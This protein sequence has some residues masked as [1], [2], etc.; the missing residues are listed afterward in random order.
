MFQSIQRTAP[1][2]A[3]ALAFV[4]VLMVGLTG[5]GSSTTTTTAAAVTE[6]TAAPTTD[7]TATAAT[8]GTTAAPKQ[9]NIAYNYATSAVNAMQEMALGATAAAESSPGV[10]FTQASPGPPDVPKQVSL[11]QAAENTSKDGIAIQSLQ[12][13]LFARPAADAKAK[14]IP[15]V[16][17]DAPIPN[18]DLVISNSNYDLG[19][20][21]ATEIIKSIPADAK[22]E[23]VMGI[24]V[25][26]LS[27]LEQRI[28]GMEDVLK[29]ERPGLTFAGPYDT[30]MT[31]TEA[32]AAW[33]EI[34]KAHPDAVAY[35]WPGSADSGALADIQRQTGKK[36]LCA[37]CDLED[38]GLQGIKDGYIMALGSPEHW[39]K[40]YIATKLLINSAQLGT[41]LPTGWWNTGSL[42]VTSANVDE[43]MARQVDNKTRLAWFQKQVDEQLANSAKYLG[44]I[45]KF[46]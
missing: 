29:K 24:A 31:P 18:I 20:M 8:T 45:S 9:V 41:P 13:D 21:V 28:K 16:A 22:G 5:C 11:L 26:G 35:M 14:N 44:P 33:S 12:P 7:T 23:V 6:T 27:V 34:V 38:K 19:A 40:G 1:W 15:L 39:M 10:T 46:N 42:L 17:V 37:G 32:Y 36:L 25:P 30:K 4:V 3:L 2:A 43:I